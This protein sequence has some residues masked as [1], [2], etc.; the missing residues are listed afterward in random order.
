[1]SNDVYYKIYAN[2]D[3]L[4]TVVCMQYFDEDDYDQ[5]RFYRENGETL[6]FDDEE[7]AI[8]FINEKFRKDF[9]DPEYQRCNSRFW[10]DRKLDG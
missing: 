5:S 1:M 7:K 4:I 2:R 3:D 8:E 9:I 10:E 6:R